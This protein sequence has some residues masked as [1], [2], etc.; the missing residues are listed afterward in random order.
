MRTTFPEDLG[1]RLEDF[2]KSVDRLVELETVR[3][4]SSSARSRDDGSTPDTLSP[5]SECIAKAR[6]LGSSTLQTGALSQI[7]GT[8]IIVSGQG[9]VDPGGFSVENVTLYTDPTDDKG[10][11]YSPYERSQVRAQIERAYLDKWRP[12]KMRSSLQ[13]SDELLEDSVVSDI[14]DWRHDDVRA[15][16]DGTPTERALFRCAPHDFTSSEMDACP[17]C[18]LD[19]NFGVRS[20]PIIDQILRETGESMRLTIEDQIING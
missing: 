17:Y 14:T 8:P 2:S 13:V 15:W 10:F 16:W 18:V 7:T 19:V 9:A 1:Q 4:R 12:Q 11:E 5:R 6:Q 20:E 3:T